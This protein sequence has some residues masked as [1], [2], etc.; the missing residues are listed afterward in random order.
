M[1]LAKGTTLEVLLEAVRGNPLKIAK[2]LVKVDAQTEV[3]GISRDS[4]GIVRG[5]DEIVLEN[6]NA[7]EPRCGTRQQFF[8]QCPAETDGGNRLAHETSPFLSSRN[9]SV[10]AMMCVILRL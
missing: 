6:L 7:I 3:G 4:R 8:P 2:G 9:S 5:N 1:S 10:R